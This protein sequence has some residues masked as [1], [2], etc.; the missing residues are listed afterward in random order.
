MT[1]GN[2]KKRQDHQNKEI[3]KAK[4]STNVLYDR[5]HRS[6]GAIATIKAHNL[7]KDVN[8][9]QGN[10][11]VCTSCKIMTM[12]SHYRGKEMNSIARHPL[13]EIQVDTVPN[14]EP[15]GLSLESR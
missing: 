1:S 10:D 14:P 6:D 12:P 9:K 7:W 8:I 11:S 13:D 4:I 2:E 15:L 3:K 5:F